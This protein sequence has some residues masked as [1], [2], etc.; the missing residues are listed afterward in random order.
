MGNLARWI[1]GA[2]VVALATLMIL[3][4]NAERLVNRVEPVALPVPGPE[5]Q[6]L[7]REA[8]VVDLHADSLLFGR[9]LLA[10][11]E[12]GHVDLPRLREG[13]VGLQAFTLVTRTPFGMNVER[14]EGDAP[15]MLTW[16]GLLRFS[17]MGVQSPF[18]RARTQAERLQEF[19]A[20]SDGGLV[21]VRDRAELETLLEARR[22]GRPVVGGLLGIEG[23]HALEGDPGK[24]VPLFE[25]GVRMVGLAHFFDNRF[26]GSA[27][28][29]EKH[30]L[31]PAGRELVRRMVAKG[32]VIDL[33]HL[34]PRAVEEL[35]AMVSVPTVVSHGGVQGTCPG[36]RNLSDA[37]IRAIAAGG[38][39]VGSGYW[40]T[41]VCGTTPA[42]VV[43]AMRHV[44]DL[45]G[46]SHVALGS[47][48]DGA[49]TMGFD[50]RALSSLTQAMRDGGI[51][52]RSIP[53]V[54]GGNALRVLR[55][56]L[57]EAPES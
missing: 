36:P 51:P 23:A 2:V 54:L 29:V 28:G 17:P 49:T 16:V 34:A 14:T 53:K 55:A 46:D 20:R 6:A 21:L 1:V 15:D 50:T 33:A 57:P 10:R 48:F 39:V 40:E 12:V 22:A 42:H 8:F 5:A 35:L 31:T 47:D 11:S 52:D 9:D 45:V 26:A 19:V 7:H 37:Q 30:G 43:A 32:V 24:L 38:G 3:A 18:E 44:I 13:G 25:A 56:V 41:A 4:W 27:H